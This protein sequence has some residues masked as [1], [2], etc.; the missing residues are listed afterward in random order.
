MRGELAP[1]LETA[2]GVSDILIVG[3]SGAVVLRQTDFFVNS[4]R[5]GAI[6][7]L[8][9]ADPEND[10][11]IV[12]TSPLTGISKNGLVADMQAARS[13]THVIREQAGNSERFQVR[14]FNYAPTLAFVMLDGDRPTGRI[15]VEMRPYQVSSSSRCHLFV[16]AKE[17]PEWFTYF[18]DVCESIWRD[19]E[20][21]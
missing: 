14:L 2:R 16:T 11:I 6:V 15:F 10:A 20:P 3:V 18:R 7:R 17:H 1:L 8:A 13:M 5:Q 21:L 4:L 19:A 9:V 12:A